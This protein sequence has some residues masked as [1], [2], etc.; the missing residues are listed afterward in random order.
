A[1]AG[2]TFESVARP[3]IMRWKY[4]KLLLNLGNAIEA[5]C[6][7][8]ARFGPLMSVLT[9]EGEAALRAAGI[10]FASAEEDAERR[11]TLLRMRRIDGQRRTGG[12]TWQSLQ[13][14]TGAMET[15]HLTG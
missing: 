5:L 9:D 12:S 7:P 11:G 10:D 3:D 14:G 6:D 2:S 1:F 4:S 8:E 15:Y 13:R